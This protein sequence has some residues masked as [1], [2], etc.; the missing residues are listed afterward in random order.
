MRS[1]PSSAPV[2]FMVVSCDKYADLWDPFFHCLQKYWPDCPYAVYL[3][4]NHKTYDAPDVTVV[5]IGEDRSYSDNLRSALSQISEPW[6]ILWLEDVFISERVDTQRFEAIIAEA[7]SIPVGYLKISPDLP[8]SYADA[9]GQEIGPIPKGVRYRSAIG[10]SLYNVETL[11]KLLTPEASAWDLDTSTISNELEEPFYALTSKAARRPPIIWAHGVIKGR[12][13]WPAIG[14]LRR[15]GFGHILAGRAR[16]GIKA[17]LYIRA[18]KLHNFMFRA[19]K[20][21]WY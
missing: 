18:F 16:L 10:L 21:H 6:V 12:W 2:A 19:L 20:K 8:L 13:Y 11:K 9:A 3:L 7:Q 4:T 14:F 1:T 15:E 5:N 17:F